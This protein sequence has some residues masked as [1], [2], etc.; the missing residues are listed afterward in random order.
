L[1]APLRAG[2]F[3]PV[4]GV[5]AADA[6]PD[7]AHPMTLAGTKLHV[8][9]LIAILGALPMVAQNK[10]TGGISGVVK[11]QTEL[12]LP[13][14]TVTVI[15]TGTGLTRTAYTETSGA[16]TMDLLPP[17]TYRVTAELEGLGRA[18]HG[19]VRVVLGTSTR[20]ALT[21]APRLTD[22]IEVTADTPL[23]DTRQ[24]GLTAVVSFEQISS[25]PILGRDFKDLILLTPGVGETFGDRVSLNGARGITT[26]YNIDGAEA[27]SDFFGEERGGTEAPFVFSQAAIREFQV[28]RTSYSAEYSRSAGGTVNA[29][30][31]SGT[32][33]VL[34]ELFWY[35]RDA[36]W[37]D[38]R[39]TGNIT[40][41]FEA[42]DVDQFGFAAGGP[43]VH[44][45]VHTFLNGDFQRISEPVN[46]FDWRQD[47]DFLDLDPAVRQAVIDKIE[48]L[49]GNS[50]DDELAYTSRQDQDTY[51]VKFDANLSNNHHLSLRWNSADYNNFP[52]ESPRMLS[53]QGNELNTSSSAVLQMESVLSSTL[54]NQM[55]LQFAVEERPI[56]A[57]TTSVPDTTISGGGVFI[58]FGQLEF[59]PN[60]TDETKWQ[61]KDNLSW[62]RGAHTIKSGFEVLTT[63]IDNLFPREL[64]G[65][66]TFSSV[67]DFLADA[68]SRFE[69]GD[70]PTDGLNAYD[71]SSWGIFIQ[72]TWSPGAN[73]SID[74]GIRYDVQDIPTPVG[75]AYPQHPE[76]VDWFE[77][78]TDN[79]APRIGFA[80]D[81]GGD[82][83]SVVRGGAGKFFS[84]LPSILYAGPTAEIP[85][86]YNRIAITCSRGGC[87]EYPNILGS[88]DFEAQAR[89][90]SLVTVVSPD[91]E[92]QEQIRSSL[93][94][95]QMLGD[96]Y[97][98]SIE[99][100]YS[101][102]SNQQR[103]V[104]IN[105][106]ATGLM[107]GNMPVYTLDSPDRPYS[108]L[109]QVRMHVSDADGEY[110]AV[111]LSTKKLALGDSRFS[112]LAHYTWSEATV[113]DSNERSTST[114]FSIDPFDAS[115][116]PGRAD[117][118]VTHRIVASGTWE[119]PWSTFVS[120]I[121]N[122]NSGT[123]YTA[124]INMSGFAMLNGIDRSGVDVPVFL[125]SNGRIVDLTL[126]NGMTAEELAAFL[127]G[128]RL[129]DRNQYDQPSFF[130]VDLRISKRF[131]IVDRYTIEVIGEVFNLTNEKNELVG[132][133]NVNYFEGRISNGQYF[134]EKNAEFGTP[135]S[136]RGNPRQ[137]Q[138]AMK[139]LF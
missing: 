73:L 97:S 127:D 95:E 120:G 6:R 90:S 57:L 92:A 131:G 25:L 114:S 87:P 75:N 132:G 49:T 22:I 68:P 8:F 2:F 129:Q 85:G 34:G 63:D 125:D 13:G 37:A 80:Y 58:R 93:A 36:G 91:L 123:P 52:S 74:Y 30:T 53:N 61:L 33:D 12:T 121:L 35:R 47:R 78:D 18:E 20:V 137:Y 111:T 102:L 39:N 135:T 24:S 70:G 15:N 110:K 38:E 62:V 81:I 77:N 119:L 46:V 65:Q 43:I 86:L 128:A 122:W 99:G 106:V 48:R 28:I 42:R 79:F 44:D 104:N 56:N 21:I 101:E 94:Y 139:F 72:D 23:V 108:D 17:G 136:F 124:G 9:A 40:E 10:T 126:A 1:P 82:G 19:N 69:Q 133:S 113:S 14:V 3:V 45:K 55:V 117:Y 105:A 29:I 7:E 50:I 88:A 116:N 26:D 134:F 83:R 138:V 59:L 100:V 4:S 96:S 130:N 103:L 51:L 60:R 32:N 5:A 16:F 115:L 67:D 89:A 118:D 84:P 66:Y 76:F 109:S 27:N 41:F 64:A 107:F 31:R 11:D 98:V 54:F 112:W 71:L